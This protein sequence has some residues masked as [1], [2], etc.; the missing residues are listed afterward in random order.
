MKNIFLKGKGMRVLPTLSLSTTKKYS[1]NENEAECIS[2]TPK[3]VVKI[4]SYASKF[5]LSPEEQQK[6]AVEILNKWR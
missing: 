2:K 3:T 4:P 5:H 6:K 1:V